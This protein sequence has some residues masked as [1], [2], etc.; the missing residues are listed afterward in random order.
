MKRWKVFDRLRLFFKEGEGVSADQPNNEPILKAE[1]ETQMI[2]EHDQSKDLEDLDEVEEALLA[3]LEKPLARNRE[4]TQHFEGAT[5]NISN[6]AESEPMTPPT[7]DKG[8]TQYLWTLQ[9]WVLV[10]RCLKITP[11]TMGCSSAT[12][13]QVIRKM[14][15]YQSHPP[16]PY[17]RIL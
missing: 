12:S 9:P 17:R 3:L 6:D 15:E 7:K 4:L 13:T 2:D 5:I 11:V 14:N 1:N 8:W 10:T 16:L